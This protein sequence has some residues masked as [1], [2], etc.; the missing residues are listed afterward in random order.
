M[1]TQS[2]NNQLTINPPVPSSVKVKVGNTPVPLLPPLDAFA[3]LTN[4]EAENVCNILWFALTHEG[5]PVEP[6]NLGNL[7]F[8]TLLITLG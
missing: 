7:A 8:K 3:F 1:S 5:L 4:K 6:R 2:I